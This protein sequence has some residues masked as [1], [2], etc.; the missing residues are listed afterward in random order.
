ML[1]SKKFTA[2]LGD[3]ALLDG[4]PAI[5]FLPWAKDAELED[6]FHELMRLFLPN[7]ILGVSD[8]VPPNA[9]IEK[10]RLVT[11]LIEKFHGE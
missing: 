2:A 7:I 6:F 11:R 8:L 10:I 9:E 4:M 5:S 3:M 1:R